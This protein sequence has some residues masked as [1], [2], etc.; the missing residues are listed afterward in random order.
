[1]SSFSGSPAMAATT[2]LERGPAPA[3]IAR[4]ALGLAVALGF[5]GTGLPHPKKKRNN[6][7]VPAGSRCA[8]GL[9][10]TR[11]MRRGRPS[12]RRSATKA[13]E[14]SWNESPVISAETSAP[15]RTKAAKISTSRRRKKTKIKLSQSYQ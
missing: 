6:M 7:T 5:T 13:C 3:V 11:P 8:S 9:R 14:N 15:M 4:D 12:P 10:V 2:K 1:M